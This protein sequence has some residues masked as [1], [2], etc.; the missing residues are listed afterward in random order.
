MA[1]FSNWGSTL[2]VSA[3]GQS[4]WAACSRHAANCGN[5]DNFIVAQS[6][7]SMAAPYVAAQIGR[8]RGSDQAAATAWLHSTSGSSHGKLS[9]SG[10]QAQ[11]PNRL[12]FKYDC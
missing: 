8:H 6:G 10:N 7:T 3:P 11:S 12:A 2:D 9:L 5:G 1:G 4:V